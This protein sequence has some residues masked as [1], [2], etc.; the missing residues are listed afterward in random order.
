MR[1]S[2]NDNRATSTRG[3]STQQRHAGV[4]PRAGVRARAG[5]GVRPRAAALALTLALVGAA[6]AQT[7]TVSTARGEATVKVGPAV[8]FAYDYGTIDTLHQLGTEVQGA[9]PLTGRLPAWAPTGA[10]NIGS[11]FEPDYE[12]VNA[13]QPD[14]VVVAG[15]SAPAYDQLARLAPTIDLTSS[16]DLLADIRR[17]VTTLAA[18]VGKPQAGEAALAG[19][20]AK[21]AAVREALAVVDN[22]MLVMVSGGSLTVVAFDNARAA[23]LYGVLGVTPT[24]ADVQSATHGEPISFE[25]LLQHDPEWLFVIDRD[26]AIGTEGA[27]PAAAV[28][29]NELMHRTTAWR[30]GHVVYLDPFDW[31][32][33]SGTGLGSLNAML[34]EL[35]AAL[36]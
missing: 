30:E 14:L 25:F 5:A 18:I 7:V 27:Q 35:G 6:T 22:G 28:L 12:T 26:A 8:V 13:E 4:R 16:G 9:P 19:L 29:D 11:L 21:V 10:I 34:D 23:L 2:A 17:N 33:V 31:Y 36:E 3:S 32:I 1:T 20:D 15:R 24:V